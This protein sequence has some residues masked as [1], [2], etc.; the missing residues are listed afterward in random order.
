MSA[1]FEPSEADL[2]QA[3]DEL[4]V[5]R[6]VTLKRPSCKRQQSRGPNYRLDDWIAAVEVQVECP[7]QRSS[8]ISLV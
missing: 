6:S 8:I 7:L 1:S 4:N 3:Q 5:G 2:Q